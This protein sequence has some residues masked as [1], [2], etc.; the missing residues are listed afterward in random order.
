[1]REFKTETINC[2]RFPRPQHTTQ[3]TYEMSD[4]MAI[5]YLL[6][7]AP[8]AP[9][10]ASMSLSPFSNAE[11]ASLAAPLPALMSLSPF[12]NAE[13][14]ALASAS[15]ALNYDYSIYLQYLRDARFFK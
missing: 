8:A 4:K 13:G 15:F 7:P 10:P 3:A 6:N 14:A 2:F 9:S 5:A 11:G 12:S 1:M